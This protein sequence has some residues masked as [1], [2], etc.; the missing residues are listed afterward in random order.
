MT[1]RIRAAGAADAPAIAGIY[2]PY[3]LSS[4]VTF[5]EQ[6]PDAAEILARMEKV[7]AAGLPYYVAES[8]GAVVAYAYAG[9]FHPRAGYRFAVEDSVY[10]GDG[11]HRKGIGSALLRRLIADCTALGYR[12]MVAVIG[13]NDAS[14]AMHARLGFLPAGRLPDIG[15]KF[16]R[17]IDVVQMQLALGEGSRTIPGGDPGRMA[18]GSG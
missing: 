16:G 2:A 7:R 8:E 14:V 11:H 17:W 12:H 15:L 10:V 4:I 5:E 6:P 1:M 13:E 3:V 18:S 9:L